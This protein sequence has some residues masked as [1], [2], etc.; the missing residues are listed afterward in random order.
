MPAPL[1]WCLVATLFAM[2]ASADSEAFADQAPKG[3]DV[4]I[5]TALTARMASKA[6]I[7]A[8]Q[9]MLT[10]KYVSAQLAG[11]RNGVI[12]ALIKRYGL[13]EADATHAWSAFFLPVVRQHI[14]DVIVDY[15]L[16]LQSSC[17]EKELEALTQL[18]ETPVLKKWS[19]TQD[20]LDIQFNFMMSFTFKNMVA[21]VF[22]K[23]GDEIRRLKTTSVG[24]PK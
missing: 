4:A 1:K 3:S 22:S 18:F 8:A 13:S 16:A 5:A 12:E 19:A 15:A 6:A 23:H 9:A 17:S 10:E 7:H 21:D 2:C 24:S 20:N 14:S 11:Q